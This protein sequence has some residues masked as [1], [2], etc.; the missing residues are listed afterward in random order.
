MTKAYF[1]AV[2][3][4]TAA[5]VSALESI[6][7]T[8]SIRLRIVDDIGLFVTQLGHIVSASWSLMVVGRCN[9]EVIDLARW[10]QGR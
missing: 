1:A 2:W 7:D 8:N 4:S 9:T 10:T 5:F 3:N 6:G